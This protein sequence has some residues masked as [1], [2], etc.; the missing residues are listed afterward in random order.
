MEHEDREAKRTWAREDYRKHRDES[1]PEEL[2]AWR[3]KQRAANRASYAKHR[4]S[5][6]ARQREYLSENHEKVSAKLK[7]Y[8]KAHQVEKRAYFRNYLRDHPDKRREYLARYRE[9]HR[10][11]TNAYMREYRLANRE[12][13]SAYRMRPEAQFQLGAQLMVRGAVACGQ[14]SKPERCEGCGKQVPPTRLH[15]HHH[16]GYDHPLEVQW[17]CSKCHGKAHRKG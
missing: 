9:T 14:L 7:A 10:D 13:L 16:R 2:A 11:K 6:R 4:E 12:K 3:E 17:L 5:R 1:S 15:G 8:R